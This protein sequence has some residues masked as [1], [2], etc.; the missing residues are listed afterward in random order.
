LKIVVLILI[1]IVP[2]CVSLTDGFENRIWSHQWNI[3]WSSARSG[4]RV[5]NYHVSPA[6]WGT[7][8]SSIGRIGVIAH[9]IGHFLGLED[10][11]DIDYS[12][13]GLGYFCLMANSW[14]YDGSQLYPPQMS[15]WSKMK[16]G[17][18][19]PRI[20]SVGLN[21]VARSEL[22]ASRQAGHHL[23]KIGDGSFGY[24][25]G[26]YLLIEYRKT[27]WLRGGIAIYHIDENAP[28]DDE[29]Y[30]GQIDRYGRVWPQNGLHYK[31]AL[32]PADGSYG[33]ERGEN[34]GNSLDLFTS[35]QYLVPKSVL[36]GA[37]LYP[38]TDTYQGGRVFETGV[39][40]YALS[41]P[42]QDFMS[43]AFW[44]GETRGW[45]WLSNY[46]VKPVQGAGSIA[47]AP[48]AS[49]P[50]SWQ[51]IISENF[52][53]GSG[54]FALGDSA[55]LENKKCQSGGG[56]VK[57][58]KS[59]DDSTISVQVDAEN[60]TDLDISFS[61][62]S[63]GLKD[64][65]EIRLEYLSGDWNL[66][67]SWMVGRD[68]I[69]VATWASTSVVWKKETPDNFVRFQFRTTSEKKGFYIDDVVIRGR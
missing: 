1:A 63:N 38:N 55:K 69:P 20:P 43:F 46:F 10:H 22:P 41:D 31:I 53:N 29:G 14:G 36:P 64:G 47:R 42:T 58:E 28:Y 37:N 5:T 57:I 54:L 33:L 15:A 21:R 24:P 23:Y 62:L 11:Y 59:G 49:L 39:E 32:V 7:S 6:L 50:S 52:D 48:S 19:T 12:G 26:E 9:E 8:G 67:K 45:N 68:S 27:E 66:L 56:C 30:P 35:G 16:L 51:T 2:D 61:F 18:T 44:D 34:Q 60:F 25:R 3:N 13:N 65:E 17:W 4:V 40:L